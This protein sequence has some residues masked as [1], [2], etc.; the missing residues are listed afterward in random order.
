MNCYHCSTNISENSLDLKVICMGVKLTDEN[1]YCQLCADN[2]DFLGDFK[3]IFDIKIK[4][5]E[6][7]IVK[8]IDPIKE[9]TSCINTFYCNKCKESVNGI[10]CEKCGLLSPLMRHPKPKKKR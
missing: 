3:P 5:E 2:I 4:T 10:K 9:I 8:L 1:W 6:K 7:P